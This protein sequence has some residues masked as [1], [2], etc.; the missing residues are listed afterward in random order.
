[1][2]PIDRMCLGREFRVRTWFISGLANLLVGIT[3]PPLQTII[4]RLGL[5]TACKIVDLLS[6]VTLLGA[7]DWVNHATLSL[8]GFSLDR[9]QCLTCSSALYTAPV[10]CPNV[11]CGVQHELTAQEP[12]VYVRADA[13][14]FM[15]SSSQGRT[16]FAFN[17]DQVGCATCGMPALIM[18][19]VACTCSPAGGTHRCFI[20]YSDQHST[21]AME[22][23]F[24]EELRDYDL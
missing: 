3:R 12:S 6:Q 14:Q 11:E 13:V 16:G 23:E 22:R 5:S 24:A 8:A 21:L 19:Q 20:G 9:V 7:F 18:S 1:M 2:H 4:D 15:T 17:V 10:A